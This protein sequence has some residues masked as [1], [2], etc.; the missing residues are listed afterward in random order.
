MGFPSIERPLG[1]HLIIVLESGSFQIDIEDDRASVT[2]RKRGKD[3]PVYDAS[4][5]LFCGL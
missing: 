1:G 2:V 5:V 4:V 3:K